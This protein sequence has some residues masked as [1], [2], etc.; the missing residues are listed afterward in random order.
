[1]RLLTVS[2]VAWLTGIAAYILVAGE[3]FRT[4]SLAGLAVYGAIFSA[5]PAV[6]AFWVVLVPLFRVLRRRNAAR[7]SFIGLS[8]GFC[9]GIAVLA[10][11]IPS[12]ASGPF[13]GEAL[14]FYFVFGLVGLVLA[15]GYL[16]PRPR[17]SA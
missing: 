4:E 13:S 8:V 3:T 11:T 16:C 1:M 10:N 6:V 2:F 12:A 9:L 7:S 14:R 5:L 17:V 15:L